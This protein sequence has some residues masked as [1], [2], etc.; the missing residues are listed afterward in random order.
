MI[1]NLTDPR[2]RPCR[3]FGLFTL[4]PGMHLSS[5]GYRVAVYVDMDSL[6]IRFGGSAHGV[7]DRRFN[8]RW[9]HCRHGRDLDMIRNLLHAD[10]VANRLFNRGELEFIIDR[11][12]END[13]SIF[14]M[15][16]DS[17]FGYHYIPLERI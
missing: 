3:S 13:T 10:Q 4:S 11:S 8:L 6:C 1:F 7:L 14:C 12:R 2:R 16:L 5:Q 17:A 9:R 15:D